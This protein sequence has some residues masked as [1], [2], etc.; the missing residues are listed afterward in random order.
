MIY[1]CYSH[2]TLIQSHPM[3]P[4]HI[5]E[6]GRLGT[7]RGARAETATVQTAVRMVAL[8]GQAFHMSWAAPTQVTQVTLDFQ[9]ENQGYG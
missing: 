2:I 8:A 9:G 6:V 5:E 3:A 1:D 4:R 7:P